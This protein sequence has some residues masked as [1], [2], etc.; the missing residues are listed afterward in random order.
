MSERLAHKPIRMVMELFDKIEEYTRE[1]EDSTRR[2]EARTSAASASTPSGSVGKEGSVAAAVGA[3]T[4]LR[5]N[6]YC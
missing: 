3:P 6:D 5:A 2:V 1:E 4:K